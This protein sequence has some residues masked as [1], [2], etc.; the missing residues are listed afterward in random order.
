MTHFKDVACKVFGRAMLL[1]ADVDR[2]CGLMKI[3]QKRKR[4]FYELPLSLV[5]TLA[6]ERAVKQEVAEKKREKREARKRR[7]E[8]G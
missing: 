6:F 2:D 4:K 3:R 8:Q 7:R 5:L 1:C